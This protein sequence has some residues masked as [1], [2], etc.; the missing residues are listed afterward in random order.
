MKKVIIGLMAM[1]IFCGLQAQ[2]NKLSKKERKQLAAMVENGSLRA[3]LPELLQSDRQCLDWTSDL[4]HKASD[5]L[6]R[7]WGLAVERKKQNDYI[8]EHIGEAVRDSSLVQKT[9]YD[10]SREEMRFQY[11]KMEY[12]E[13]R[14]DQAADRRAMP[15]GR[16][17]TL[18]LRHNSMRHN[19]YSPYEV[20]QEGEHMK[21]TYGRTESTIHYD[22]AM[23]DSLTSIFE[24][25]RLYQL[26]SSYRV[27][28]CPLPDAMI[29]ADLFDGDNWTMTA[30]FDDGTVI[31][32]GG[33][34]LPGLRVTALEHFLDGLIKVAM[35]DRDDE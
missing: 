10:I 3:A 26:H 25:E 28:G 24:R 15:K 7:G 23:L 12:N 1:A 4:K 21:L 18:S 29:H 30:C 31:S 34:F 27:K 2:E 33:M 20:R 5:E 19:P 17:T 8:K 11:F 13:F 35:S 22:L 6:E 32:S 14:S 16:I 9:L